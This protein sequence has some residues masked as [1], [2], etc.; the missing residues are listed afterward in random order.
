M[1]YSELKKILKKHGCKFH[2]DGGRHEI[3]HSPITNKMFPIG[4]HKSEEVAKGTLKAI[5]QQAGIE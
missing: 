3:W 2:H 4:R 5:M 1:T